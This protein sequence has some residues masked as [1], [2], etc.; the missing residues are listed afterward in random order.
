MRITTLVLTAS[1]ASLA[2]CGGSGGSTD[3]QP[4]LRFADRTDT[5]ISRIINAAVGAEMF[6]AQAQVDQFGDTFDPDPCPQ[7]AISG[8]TATVTGGCTTADGVAIGGGAVVTNPLGWDQIETTFGADATYELDGL[9][10]TE[11]GFTQTY[12]GVIRIAGDFRSWDADLTTDAFGV[13]LR[14]DLYMS[15][16][17]SATRVTCNVGNS[18]VELIG[19]G[20]AT[21]SGTQRVVDQ[22]V[23]TDLTLR[24]VDTLTVHVAHNCIAWTISGTDR[25]APGPA[26]P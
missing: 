17:G 4:T 18:G 12:D 22:M 16:S 24:G 20:G 26:C 10:F 1:L 14:T 5:E 13:P 19:V 6:Q 25:H 23:T 8:T 9:S 3:I 15:C 11:S 2:G 7:L 21:V